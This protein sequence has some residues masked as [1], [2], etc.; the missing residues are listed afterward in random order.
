M[1]G[2]HLLTL[3]VF[4]YYLKE[5]LGI[6]AAEIEPFDTYWKEQ[7]SKYNAN[8]D[9]IHLPKT[10]FEGKLFHDRNNLGDSNYFFLDCS[11]RNPDT[12]SPPKTII[13]LKEKVKLP[14]RNKACL[15]YTSMI[16]GWV[17]GDDDALPEELYQEL[18]D[19]SWQF[20]RHGKIL[21]S[22]IIEAWRSRQEWDVPDFGSHVLII[23]YP[24]KD[25]YERSSKLIFG[26]WV[27]LLLYRH[28][29]WYSYQ[30]SRGNKDK[31]R[32]TFNKAVKDLQSYNTYNLQQLGT[33]LESNLYSL[34]DY[35]TDL[36]TISSHQHTLDTNLYNYNLVVK[37]F[38]EK[39][40]DDCK[41]N[42]WANDLK[43]LEKFSNIV[44]IKYEKQL[45][46]D[47]AILAPGLAVLSGLTETIRGL[48]EVQ[49]AE[50]DRQQTNTIAIVGLGLAASSSVAGIVATQVYQPE[51]N[52]SD[53]LFWSQGNHRLD[54]LPAMAVS[55]AIPVVV[56]IVLGIRWYQNRHKPSK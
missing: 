35:S 7:R 33:A 4:Y 12:S 30:E 6:T 27:S 53:R 40:N 1:A 24:N 32:K 56:A 54:W 9:T 50:I 48:V 47:Y 21:G 42:L 28:K 13:K 18:V 51:N 29:I 23:L 16:Y 14:E 39:V 43:F 25:T 22:R 36:N 11:I 38:T 55:L 19:D 41:I 31:I 3:N 44:E 8:A 46:K 34:T 15:G 45:E 49:Q 26:G 17:E 2:I 5:G 10:E 20:Q 52:K 37:Q